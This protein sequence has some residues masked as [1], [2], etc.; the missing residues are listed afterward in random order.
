MERMFQLEQRRVRAIAV[1]RQPTLTVPQR[2]TQRGGD[3]S[4]GGVIAL[5]QMAGRLAPRETDA[6][7]L[8]ASR[9]AASVVRKRLQ[10]SSHSLLPTRQASST[11]PT[12]R[13]T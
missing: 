4:Q 8:A 9:S 6:R 11:A 10:T 12:S 5:R 3:A 1:R 7:G 13:Q 2:D